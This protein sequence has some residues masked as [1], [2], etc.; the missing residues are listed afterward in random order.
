MSLN[1]N[2]SLIAKQDCCGCTACS[3]CCPVDAI[4][5]V[6][7]SEGFL[8][9]SVD[10]DRCIS[11]GKCLNVCRDVK[12]YPDEQQIFACRSNSDELRAR[13]SSGGIFSLLAEQMFE[14]SGGVCAV[15]YSDD[16]KECLHK[17]IL[18]KDGLD[19][20]RRAK[21]V[22]SKKYDIFRRVKEFLQTGR[23]LLFCGTP[24]EVGGLRQFL[25]KEYPNL[26]TCDLICGCT[27]SPDVYRRYIGFLSDQYQS[28]VTNVNFKDKRK[29]WRG[30]AIAVTFANG[31]E[32]YNSI[33]DDDYCV[34]FHSRYN[35]RPSCFHCKYRNLKRTSDITLGDFWAIERYCPEFDDNKGTSF[36]LV[37]SRKGREWLAK[38][39]EM[40]MHEMHIDLEDYSSKYNWCMHRNPT[41][42]PDQD[43]RTFYQ[44]VHTMRFDEMARKDLAE[45]KQIRKQRKLNNK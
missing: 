3:S 24:C 9:P 10:A 29:G 30:K 36:V 7:D 16:C 32:Y 25:N 33:L 14:S 45:I 11:C 44:D 23:M 8:Y 26:L 35:I 40:D 13:S 41:G 27:S 17:I 34:S 20:L 43:R 19:D 38:I 5:M 18:S 39:E 22:Q 31:Q 2:I 4:S 6:G 12:F 37:N 21:F 15:G 42:M 1:N 28:D